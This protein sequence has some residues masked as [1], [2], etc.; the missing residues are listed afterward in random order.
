MSTYDDI[1]TKNSEDEGAVIAVRLRKEDKE[2]IGTTKE[3]MGAS[4]LAYGGLKYVGTACFYEFLKYENAIRLVELG[5]RT[6]LLPHTV[7]HSIDV[8]KT[9]DDELLYFNRRHFRRVFQKYGHLYI[10]DERQN[11]W[12]Y[13]S[14]PYSKFVLNKSLIDSFG[15]FRRDEDF[16]DMDSLGLER[17]ASKLA[18][19]KLIRKK[20]IK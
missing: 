3:F 7:D 17:E 15:D 12:I 10:Y 6:Q 20:G 4:I 8:L 9:I 11:G 5:H 14:T 2:R 18:I 16:T 19:R 13:Y 1:W